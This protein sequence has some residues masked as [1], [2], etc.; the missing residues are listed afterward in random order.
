MTAERPEGQEPEA[1]KERLKRP[2]EE[3]KDL[4]APPE[5]SDEVRGGLDG[6]S[7]DTFF[8]Y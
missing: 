8:K 4:D 3:I 5:D 7:K 6:G 2:T 1:E